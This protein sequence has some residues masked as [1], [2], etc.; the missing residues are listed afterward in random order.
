[1]LHE[2][3]QYRQTCFLRLCHRTW[4]GCE[5][6]ES[7]SDLHGSTHSYPLDLRLPTYFTEDSLLRDHAVTELAL[8][9]LCKS[10]EN[11]VC[12]LNGAKPIERSSQSSFTGD[13]HGSMTR[14]LSTFGFQNENLC[15]IDSISNPSIWISM[16]WCVSSYVLFL[17][18]ENQLVPLMPT[19]T[20]G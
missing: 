8:L 19:I 16:L 9:Q 1:M 4:I 20:V 18:C 14:G 15:R 11:V 12:L 13:L 17:A 6:S 10:L 5:R 3:R 2:L 7:T